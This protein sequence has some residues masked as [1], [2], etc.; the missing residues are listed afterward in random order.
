MTRQR[1]RNSTFL[2]VSVRALSPRGCAALSPVNACAETTCGVMFSGLFLARCRIV[3]FLWCDKNAETPGRQLCHEAAVGFPLPVL[4]KPVQ[5]ML[6]ELFRPQP[7]K[8]PS[9]SAL[10]EL[11][12]SLLGP[13]VVARPGFPAA[14]RRAR[15]TAAS[16]SDIQNRKSG[17]PRSPGLANREGFAPRSRPGRPRPS[18]SSR[19][20]QG[21][22]VQ[23][24]GLG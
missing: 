6:V 2:G 3:V 17:S 20:P 8:P 5:A 9:F 22:S 24:P 1:A 21:R 13:G 14:P 4:R 16:N 23:W 19:H 7:I 12:P 15:S 10:L 18:E 11:P